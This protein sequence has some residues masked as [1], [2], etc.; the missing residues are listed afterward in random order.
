MDT[1]L[2]PSEISELI[3][4]RI[5]KFDVVSEARNEG[6]VVSLSDGIARVHG[7]ADA[8]QGEMIEF[9]GDT[10]GHGFEPGARLRRRGDAWADYGHIVRRRRGPLHRQDHRGAGWRSGLLGPGCRL[11]WATSCRRCKGDIAVRCHQFT[12]G[13]GGA[14]ASSGVSR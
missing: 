11:R 4:E 10:Y 3:R 14:Q 12:G 6:T 7:L 2:N 1:Q 5:E 13:E 8:A 9:P